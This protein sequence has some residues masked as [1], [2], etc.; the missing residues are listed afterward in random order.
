MIKFLELMI[1]EAGGLAL[2]ISEKED[3]GVDHKS[4][5]DIVTRADRDV[6]QFIIE[7]IRKTYPDHSIVGEETGEHSGH[8]YRWVIDPIDGT[9][10]Y[11]HRLPNYSVSIG[12]EKEGEVILAGVYAPALHELYLAEKGGG[13]TLNQKKIKVNTTQ[14]LNESI[15]AT[16]FACLRDNLEANNLP[17]LCE[18]LPHLRDMR[19]LGSAAHELCLI[20]KGSLEGFWE[21]NLKIHDIAAASLILLEAGG[22]LTDFSG[23]PLTS[24]DEVLATN[25]VIHEQIVEIFKRVSD[26]N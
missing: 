22:R 14:A 21:L 23:Q 10:S 13:A 5:K 24:P 17:Y 12:L 8:T 7:K 15:L 6:E 18:L 3:L 11:A 4:D 1:L 25:G 20:A 19:R 9:A 16:G 2:E 26:E